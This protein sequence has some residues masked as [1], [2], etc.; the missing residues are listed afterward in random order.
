VKHILTCLFIGLISVHAEVSAQTYSL[1]LKDMPLRNV[2]R[3]IERQGDY[4]F[5]FSD[6]VVDLNRRVQIEVSDATIEQI[7]DKILKP[8]DLS[9]QILENNL[10]IIRCDMAVQQNLVVSGMVTDALGEPLPGVSVILKGTTNGTTTNPNGEFIISVSNRNT[11][12]N[13]SFIGFTSKEIIVGNRTIINVTLEEDNYQ[14]SEV[15]VTALGIK[16]A[17]KALSY[18]VQEVKGVELT[19]V[20]SANFINSLSGKVAGVQINSGAA[21]H[22]SAVKVVMRGPKSLSK[23]NN[24][25]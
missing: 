25:L 24:A 15:I 21:G 14:L 6:D 3:T 19:T 8:S 7:L 4:R 1:S 5:F 22:G 11:A 18:H 16:R 13:F 12:L 9:Y 10:I 2:I 23:N 20:K 17:E